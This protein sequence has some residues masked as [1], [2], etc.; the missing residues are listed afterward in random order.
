MP[1]M[2]TFPSLAGREKAIKKALSSN[3]PSISAKS[4]EY[5]RYQCNSPIYDGRYDAND[6]TDTIAP[7]IQLFHPAFAHFLDDV[8]NND[9]P[10][11]EDVIR[12]TVE[13]MRNSSGIY[14]SEDQRTA[15]LQSVLEDALG[16]K[17]VKRVNADASKADGVYEAELRGSKV[18]VIVVLLEQK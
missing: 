17:I 18:K 11:P 16:V 12:V 4:Q 7:P 9:L 8:K 13:Y 1:L 10:V 6:P 3:S 14:G 2:R 5:R 15:A